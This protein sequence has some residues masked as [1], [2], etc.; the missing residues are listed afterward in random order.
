MVL[1]SG[2]RKFFLPVLCQEPRTVVQSKKKFV[3]SDKKGCST[4]AISCSTVASILESKRFATRGVAR[5]F[6][7]G[8][9]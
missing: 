1:S 9:A 6:K 4:V 8:G 3:V 5:N 2:S 7:R